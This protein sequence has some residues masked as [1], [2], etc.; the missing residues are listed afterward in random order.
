LAAGLAPAAVP[1]GT[2]SRIWTEA[3]N[4]SR[5][6]KI[7]LA[8]RLH[9]L[10][11]TETRT[12]ERNIMSAENENN[13][14]PLR[15]IFQHAACVIGIAAAVGTGLAHSGSSLQL[16]SAVLMGTAYVLKR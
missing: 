15:E 10:Y 13:S 8:C 16:A 14:H 3:A 1:S 11:V 2:Q 12:K 4:L 9:S 6:S 5:E 7:F